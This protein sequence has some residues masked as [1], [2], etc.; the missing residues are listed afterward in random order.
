ML[1]PCVLWIDP[2]LVTG[3]AWLL[4]G[5][6]F[7]TGEY[8]FM[9]A[10]TRIEN[11]CTMYGSS[12][13]VGWERFTIGPRTPPLDA[14]HAIEMIGVARRYA[15][16]YGCRILTE[17][18]QRTPKPLDQRRLK[19][20]GWWLPGKKDSQSASNH[21]LSWLLKQGE[22]PPRERAILDSLT[23]RAS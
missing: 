12:C 22:V 6:Q 21:L 11:T 9:E 2:G 17:A 16:R 15:T 7:H 18:Q 8:G 4:D 23:G 20:L 1:P 5:W 19:A 10:G 13:W 14:H 3:L